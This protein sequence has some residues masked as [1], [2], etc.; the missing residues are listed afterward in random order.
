MAQS[1]FLMPTALRIAISGILC[2][3]SLAQAADSSPNNVLEEIVVT[4]TRH[5]E[6]L[7][8]VPISV[9]AI[10]QESLDIKGI[11]DIN[12]VAR[13]TPGVNVDN[14]GTSNI[15]IRGI[16]S[17]G[18]AGTTG[19]Y[20]D[21]T[22]IQ[23]RTIAFN[24]DEALPKSFDIDRVEVLR[25]PQG[26]LFGAGSEG[27]TVRYITTPASLTQSSVYSRD[28]ISYT[29]GGKPSYE[30]GLA[31]GGPVIDGTL[32]VRATVWF[33]NDGAWIERVDPNNPSNV[34][35]S[36]AN[37][38]RTALLRLSAVWKASDSVTISP[39]IFYQDRKA[40]D[41]SVYWPLYSNPGSHDFVS[42]NPTAQPVPD[43][44]YL[45][46]LKFEYDMGF[47]SLISNTSYYHR[48]QS[49]GYDGTLY[50]LGFYQNYIFRANDP[51]TPLLLDNTG[52]HL[53]AGATDYRAP[54][55]V[56]NTQQNF[57]QEI[58]MQSSDIH[59][60]IAW[61]A[62]LFYERNR[63]N[64]LEQVH[65]P[66]LNQ[67]L[68]AMGNAYPNSIASPIGNDYVTPN[69]GVGFDPRYPS[70]SYF[71]NS[72]ATDEQKAVYGE[73]NYSP[74]DAFKLTLGARFAQSSFSQS[75]M[76]GGPQ[77]YGPT[78][79]V[80]AVANTENSFTPK[81][82]VSYQINPTNMV[83]AT[84]STGFRPG[85][86]NNPVPYASCA[87]DFQTFGIKNSPAS[88]QSDSVKSY[89]VGTKDTINGVL[90][91][92]TSA[93]YIRWNNI[94]QTVL[95]P[96]CQISWIQNL[97]QAVAKGFDFQAE[98][99][100]DSGLTAEIAAG[101]TD[102][103]YTADSLISPTS[104]ALPVVRAGD[105]IVGQSGQANPP[106]TASIGLEY[107]FA[108]GN[109]ESYARF[110]DEYEQTAKWLTPSLDPN[111]SQYTPGNFAVPSTNY[112]SF[113]LGTTLGSWKV[114]MFIDNLFDSHA[115]GNYN[116][117]IT[118][119]GI[120]DPTLAANTRL[121]RIYTFRPRTLGLT[122]TYRQ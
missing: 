63:Q 42:A 84:Y 23:M 121:E 13:F 33:R 99:A 82:G 103:R 7:S 116:Y 101:Y 18:G 1:R 8:K 104:Q 90:R 97:G 75:A 32:G 102:A 108:I 64:Y 83:Y 14:S 21:D 81:V 68:M 115:I 87:D 20:I 107:K 95:P 5:E 49:D 113:R 79:N 66:A 96:V 78:V 94:Q 60:P 28:E 3:T 10:T 54:A 25:G 9:T 73:L 37:Q 2:S 67:L 106:V 34:V 22:P 111:T 105:A 16:S 120:A 119:A 98:Y 19:I 12:D 38:Q 53:P 92:A 93:Y 61:T 45:P 117:T 31:G 77:L 88:Y 47:A 30:V 76:T 50:N 56:Q 26:T 89:E 122:F 29:Q 46:A 85:G 44:F 43:T 27:G 41:G 51:S 15:S 86:G 109:R 59:A 52:V 114:A 6:N 58:R 57:V 74:T 36:N 24:P 40:N 69:F 35:D 118:P 11:K 48:Q 72:N 62:G 4:A 65:D 55:T 110:D 17:S 80:P 112:A 91:I 71:L 70:D 100:F 39:S